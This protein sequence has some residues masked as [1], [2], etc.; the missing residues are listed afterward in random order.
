[1]AYNLYTIESYLFIRAST[2]KSAPYTAFF[3]RRILYRRRK[4]KTGVVG[5]FFF[6][7]FV[8]PGRKRRCPPTPNPQML[9]L[10]NRTLSIQV[11]V[12]YEH[13]KLIYLFLLSL[14]LITYCSKAQSVTSTVTFDHQSLMINGK[15]TFIYSG[16]FHYFRCPP[17]LWRQRFQTIRAAG[18]NAVDTYIPWSRH[19]KKMPRSIEDYT[20]ID[21]S[22]CNTWLKMAEEFGFYVIARPG[23]FICAEYDRGGYPGWLTTLR[24]SQPRR[25][26]WYRSDDPVYLQ[27]AAH[28]MNAACQLIAEHQVTR[29]APGTGGVIMVQVENEF[30][31]VYFP[32]E[33]K[34]AALRSLVKT[35]LDK[36]INVPLIACESPEISHTTDTLIRKHLIETN[37]FYP[38]N[39]INSIKKKIDA[40][41]AVQPHAP[42][43]V[44]ELQGGWFSYVWGTPTFKHDEDFY[45]DGRTPAQ[46]Q[47]LT[48]YC[49]QNGESIVNFYMLFGGTNLDN[50]E[51]KD[52]QSSYDFGA[53]I[54]ENGQ[55]GEKYKRIKAIGQFLK[56]H[57]TELLNSA[58]DTTLVVSGDLQQIEVAERHTKTGARFVFIRSNDPAS[59]H[60]GQVTVKDLHSALT[61]PYSLEPNG[62][63]VLYLPPGATNAA[64]GIWYPQLSGAGRRIDSAK[65]IVIPLQ[66][67]KQHPVMIH[68]WLPMQMGENLLDKGVYD[69][70]YVYYK[71]SF[72]LADTIYEKGG[73]LRVTYPW[74]KAGS[75]DKGQGMKDEIIVLLKGRQLQPSPGGLPGDYK[76]PPHQL[77]TGT[78]D[79]TILYQNAGY[80]KEFIY[81]EK[82]AGITDIRLLQQSETTP[83][84]HWKVS[85][86]DITDSL[87]PDSL[88]QHST[89]QNF[90]AEGTDLTGTPF[91]KQSIFT[92][93]IPIT[94]HQLDHKTTGLYFTQLGDIAQVYINGQLAGK[95]QSRITSRTFDLKALLKPGENKVTVITQNYDQYAPGGIS[96]PL[97]AT[98]PEAGIN[99]TQ[100]SYSTARP[101]KS[102]QTTRGIKDDQLLGWS[103]FTF[104]LPANALTYV[105][106]I[107][108]E[109]NCNLYLN[110]HPIGRYWKNGQ[111][112]DFYLPECWLNKKGGINRI[113]LLINRSGG[114]EYNTSINIRSC[115]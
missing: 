91:L 2:S 23:P 92:T 17:Q 30:S 103:N 85:T 53:P 86:S 22:E 29:R 49:I 109:Q 43:M 41:R 95:S 61:L 7:A 52:M 100:F 26:M 62:S 47:N 10:A 32:E 69:N 21:L 20:G 44:T 40:L 98:T 5:S 50:T 87:N 4:N 15:R 1:M 93:S 90:N 48:L 65:S 99:P 104:T 19:E 66:K 60:S 80:A 72:T 38:Y 115:Y 97:L 12:C 73:V 111:Q 63:I 34:I 81:M 78:H 113:D 102:A 75:L 3:T 74:L 18:F 28:W 83:L 16:S 13:M 82:A 64:A 88:L 68:D 55:T 57:E 56:A 108:S 45:I 42:L 54:R 25:W 79:F 31:H 110:G 77:A 71:A 6:L 36:G 46:A 70:R 84:P 27:W 106:Q 107:K 67:S 8:P 39:H 11:N 76:I 112:T 58:I 51:S 105:A 14:C 114:K 101:F 96:M 89:W 94:Q 37:N 35:A 9:R 24:P 59:P 33:A